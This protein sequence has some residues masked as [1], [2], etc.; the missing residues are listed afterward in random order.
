MH[1]NK[2]EMNGTLKDG[3]FV[4]IMNEFKIKFFQALCCTG[5]IFCTVG[6]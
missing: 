4:P 3:A 6:V 2:K 5:D 1:N